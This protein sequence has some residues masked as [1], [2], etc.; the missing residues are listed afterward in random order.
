ML[1]YVHHIKKLIKLSTLEKRVLII[2]I[3]TN[4]III[5]RER[6]KRVLSALL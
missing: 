5:L 2:F 1:T 3:K 6:M 4:L